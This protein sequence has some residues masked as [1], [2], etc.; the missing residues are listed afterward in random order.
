MA[1]GEKTAETFFF[2]LSLS[3]KGG[4]RTRAHTHAHC[5]HTHTKRPRDC[6]PR[7]SHFGESQLQSEGHSAPACA[8][9]PRARS[10][11]ACLKATTTTTTKNYF[12]LFFFTSSVENVSPV[13]NRCATLK[14][15]NAQ[16]RPLR[17]SSTHTLTERER[18]RANNMSIINTLPL[19]R[20]RAESCACGRARACMRGLLILLRARSGLALLQ[21]RAGNIFLILF[22]Q[23]RPG[24]ALTG[25]R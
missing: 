25:R 16:I 15:K 1:R 17:L 12:T 8:R 10:E 19:K 4:H 22:V 5:I 18:E 9:V 2:P 14:G 6:P 11:S 21:R 20:T 24:L 3:Q 23:R 13:C 7:A